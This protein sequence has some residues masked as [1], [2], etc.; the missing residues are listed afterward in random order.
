[1]QQYGVF[2]VPPFW[3]NSDSKEATKTNWSHVFSAEKIC[4][5]ACLPN[6]QSIDP[7]THAW[8]ANRQLQT[9]QENVTPSQHIALFHNKNHNTESA[10]F[11]NLLQKVP[12]WKK[13]PKWWF[14]LVFHDTIEWRGIGSIFIQMESRGQSCLFCLSHIHFRRVL[15][16]EA[17]FAQLVLAPR[18]PGAFVTHW[19]TIFTFH[20]STTR[21]GRKLSGRYC[22]EITMSFSLSKELQSPGMKEAGLMGE[23]ITCHGYKNG[24]SSKDSLRGNWREIGFFFFQP[25]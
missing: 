2:D 14:A 22:D 9:Y 3:S 10:S 7:P 17:L 4:S 18:E 11:C 24:W 20:F 23:M 15:M 16:R 5:Y 25:L 19:A 21:S 1:M 8:Q 13:L 6:P 12:S